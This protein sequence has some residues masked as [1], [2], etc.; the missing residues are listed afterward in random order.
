MSFLLGQLHV[1]KDVYFVKLSIVQFDREHGII[2][3]KC[4]LL[5]AEVIVFSVKVTQISLC[6]K[7][8]S[9]SL[10]LHLHSEQRCAVDH[11]CTLLYESIHRDKEL[12]MCYHN[13]TRAE[14]CSRV[15]AHVHQHMTTIAI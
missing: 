5:L 7:T 4:V 2:D 1:Q 8:V 10:N 9:Y 11:V 6:R 12:A 3:L 15:S 14:T 13:Y